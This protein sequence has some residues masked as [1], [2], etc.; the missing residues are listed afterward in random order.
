MN[1][2]KNITI[3]GLGCTAFTVSFGIVVGKAVG[4]LVAAFIDGMTTGLI[5][6]MARNGNGACMKVCDENGI[7]YS[8]DDNPEQ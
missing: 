1:N 3:K 6:L 8:D 4:G 5:Q 7:K 2:K